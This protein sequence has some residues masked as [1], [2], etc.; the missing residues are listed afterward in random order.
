MTSGWR[1][2]LT[3]L[4]SDVWHTSCVETRLGFRFG[5]QS[6]KG[7]A[8]GA[9]SSCSIPALWREPGPLAEQRAARGTRQ[10]FL[11]RI[12]EG[13]SQGCHLWPVRAG[14]VGRPV[15]RPTDGRRR[16]GA[17]DPA[18][19]HHPPDV[20]RPAALATRSGG[21]ARA[22]G[23]RRRAMGRAR[24]LSRF[25]KAHSRHPRHDRAGSGGLRGSSG[26][27]GPAGRQRD[28][29]RHRAVVRRPAHRRV[30]RRA[31]GG[32]QDPRSRAAGRLRELPVH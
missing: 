6:C 16:S 31:G 19:R 12:R 10:V 9:G 29:L 20:H 26:G 7:G 11:R 18:R 15:S 22:Q 30:P 8:F 3:R 14:R 21:G 25:E 27:G 5:R 24:V 23:A 13:A 28:S 17:H 1:K 4:W 2:S 32:R